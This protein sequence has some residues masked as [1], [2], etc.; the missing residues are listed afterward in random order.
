MRNSLRWANSTHISLDKCSLPP[1]T[2]LHIFH[3]TLHFLYI[4]VN[5]IYCFASEISFPQRG[6]LTFCFTTLVHMS[7]K[8]FCLSFAYDAPKIWMFSHFPPLLRQKLKRY[9]KSKNIP[10]LIFA[11]SG[12]I[13]WI[14]ILWPRIYFQMEIKYHKNIIRIPCLV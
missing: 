5:L 1:E 4:K 2:E 6:T 14:A 11:I 9:L 8:H 12:Y 3:E 7:N 10:T 13:I